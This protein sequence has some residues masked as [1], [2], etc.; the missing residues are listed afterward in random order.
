MLPRERLYEIGAELLTRPGHEKVRALTHALLV[1]GLGASSRDID[2]ERPLPE[3]RGRVDALLGETVFEFKSD[4][5]RER[6]DA[7]EELTRYLTDRE[8]TTGLRFVGIATDGAEFSP[9]ELRRGRLVQLRGF[10]LARDGV[11]DLLAWLDTAVSVRP[12]LE[13]APEAVRRE[14]GRDSLVYERAR[15]RLE[16]LWVEVR[17]RSDVAL[18]RQ[19]WA[20]LLAR[21]YGTSVDQDDLFFQHTYLTIVAKTMAAR[22][23]G[24]DP[25]TATDL[26]SGTAFRNASIA[27]A[28][29][30]DFFDWVVDAA[31]GA[32]LV[33]RIAHQASRFR[34]A[35]IATDVLKGLY[36]SLIDPAQRHD[37][38]EYYT[39]DWLAQRMCAE[40]ITDPLAERVLDP[41]CGS[42]TFLFQAVRRYL[43]AADAAGISNRDA[44]SRCTG[45]VL[46]IDVHPVAVIIARVTYLLALGEARLRDHPPMALPVYLGDALQWNTRIT[47]VGQREIEIRVPD[48][49]RPLYFP[50]T[51]TRDPTVFD[52]VLGAMLDH[53]ERHADEAAYDAWLQRQGFSDAGER[54]ELGA[55]YALVRELREAGRDH[56]WGYVA[57]N[58]SRP[59][60]L[61]TEAQQAD[62]VIGNPPWLSYRYMAPAMQRQ[63]RGECRAR[64][65][66]AGGNVAT[67]QDLSGYFYARSAELYL[68]PGGTIAFVMPYAALGRRQFAGFR[69]GRYGPSH[70]SVRFEEAWAFDEHV[71]PLFPVPSCVLFARAGEPGPLPPTVTAHAGDLPR[72][73]ASQEE[74]RIALRSYQVPWPA[75]ADNDEAVYRAAFRQG[76]ILVPRLFSVVDPVPL[77]PLGGNPEAPVVTSRRS[78]LEKPPWSRLPSVRGPVEKQFLRRLF[79]GESIAPY[80]LLRPALAVVPWDSELW[81]L[82]D[83]RNASASGYPHLAAWLG[84]AERLWGMHGRSGLSYRGQIDYYGKLSGQFPIPPVRVVYPKSGTFAAA[85]VVTDP[86]AV[87]DETLYWAAVPL[88]EARYLET[89][90]NSSTAG[91]RV[92]SSQ[93]RGQ[94]G[95]RDL[96]KVLLDLPIPKFDPS[97]A[98]HQELLGAAVRA[99]A[100]AQHVALPED[101]HF[102]RARALIRN[103]LA[104][105]GISDEVDDLV[106]QLLGF[107]VLLGPAKRAAESPAPYQGPGTV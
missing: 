84:E 31:G 1:D 55:T 74:A 70:G 13:P 87:I 82:L 92:A 60:W 43:A 89:I 93:S 64:G 81:G 72:R 45:Q 30:S 20:D 51:V 95:A 27:G 61:S 90:L 106:A 9:Y 97:D 75:A 105:D 12:D 5:R 62:V 8:R 41:A 78:R 22:I 38:G 15:A 85:A 4:L 50:F 35:E 56:I 36:E 65:L 34:L 32:D 77:G 53:S 103:A 59:I 79:L 88:D 37:L 2:F 23:L 14:L 68:K 71:Q 102:V 96:A 11:G 98:L 10:V 67:T 83:A 104:A 99:E 7:E 80:R 101:V 28:V 46:G 107:A 25:A 18:R 48:A 42:G 3:V 16:A 26:L 47:F 29:E 21:V 33:E 44:I 94:W 24:V 91:T 69:T 19:L 100:V 66:W 63:F 73:D 6:R 40:V 54:A 39:P 17:G 49:P 58:L 52:A 57:R 86:D 76:A